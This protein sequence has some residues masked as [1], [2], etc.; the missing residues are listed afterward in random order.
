MMSLYD[1]ELETRK[2]KTT[3]I[4]NLFHFSELG[5]LDRPGSS[6]PGKFFPVAAVIDYLLSSE[7]LVQQQHVL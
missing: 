2:D 6:P 1:G 4:I 3:P 7:N 5:S